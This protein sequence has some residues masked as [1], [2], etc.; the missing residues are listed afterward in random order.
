MQQDRLVDV[1]WI[2]SNKNVN[3]L[4]PVDFGVQP[5]SSMNKW[6]RTHTYEENEI[7]EAKYAMLACLTD[8]MTPYLFHKLCFDF[9]IFRYN[10]R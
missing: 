4:S 2:I 9:L 5:P 8:H 10:T 1:S 7:N 3:G 6:H